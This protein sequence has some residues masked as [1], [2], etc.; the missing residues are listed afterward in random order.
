MI[1]ID[2]IEKFVCQ[3][4]TR[5]LADKNFSVV[6]KNIA[7][8]NSTIK[9]LEIQNNGNTNSIESYYA[10]SFFNL[11]K[12]RLYSALFAYANAIE[13]ETNTENL[14]QSL[15]DVSSIKTGCFSQLTG[16]QKFHY[17]MVEW[18]LNLAIFVSSNVSCDS[19]HKL[20]QAGLKPYSKSDLPIVITAGGCDAMVEDK[21]DEYATFFNQSFSSFHGTIISGGTDAGISKITGDIEFEGIQKI[22]YLPS[23]Y[24]A[25]CQVHPSYEIIKTSGNGFSV[26]EP[27]QIWTDLLASGISPDSVKLIGVNGGNISAFEFRLALILGG[28][29]GIIKGS[30]RAADQIITTPVWSK[31]KNLHILS[32]DTQ[33][34]K[35][36]ISG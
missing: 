10:L 24:T 28:Q 15:S 5:I 16:S 11:L 18:F 33:V 35:N 22:G 32:E 1:K 4:N 8:I 21:M 19:H 26:L 12:G 29:T 14:K 36:F 25:P 20:H 2:E 9:H 30:G 27:I 17:D 23:Q 7:Q 3:I 13:L 34:V 31:K 6:E